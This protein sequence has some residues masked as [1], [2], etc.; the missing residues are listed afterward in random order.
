M[1]DVATRSK[2]RCNRWTWSGGKQ[3]NR[4]RI[5]VNF[6]LFC[7]NGDVVWDINARMANIIMLKGIEW[8]VVVGIAIGAGSIFLGRQTIV[9]VVIVI[10]TLIV[11]LWVHNGMFGMQRFG[12]NF[13]VFT[14]RKRQSVDGSTLAMSQKDRTSNLCLSFI[15]QQRLGHALGIKVVRGCVRLMT[16]VR[17]PVD[18]ANQGSL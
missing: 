9:V 3:I 8:G 5:L 6:L 7:N 4:P 14:T 18:I 16:L 10:A 11:I 15:R 2:L 13:D 17:T 12:T 1:V